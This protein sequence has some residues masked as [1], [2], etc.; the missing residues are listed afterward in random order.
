MIAAGAV[1]L[2]VMAL[3]SSVLG[4]NKPSSQI[5]VGV[6]NFLH[7][8]LAQAQT[9]LRA[10]NVSFAYDAG[11][12]L[13]GVDDKTNWIVCA[14]HAPRDSDFDKQVGGDAITA[15]SAQVWL[16]LGHYQC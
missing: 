2:A 11:Q 3:L 15:L 5:P 6:P 12:G 16:D 7:L 8:T 14:E 1:F 13:F 4:W 9:Q 10:A